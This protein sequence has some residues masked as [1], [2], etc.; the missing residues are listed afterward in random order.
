MLDIL[1]RRES[2]FNRFSAHMLVRTRWFELAPRAVCFHGRSTDP[3]GWRL[4][5]LR[6]SP[7]QRNRRFR[8]VSLES[9]KRHRH[10]RQAYCEVDLPFGSGGGFK[11]VTF[12]A[13]RSL[14][15]SGQPR[16][17]ARCSG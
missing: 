2:R 7:E 6:E 10:P 1:L 15:A 5:E 8:N 9:G 17:I 14:R 16:V 12:S 13:S 3:L 11:S 4:V